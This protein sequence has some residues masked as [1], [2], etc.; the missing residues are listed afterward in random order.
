[1][2]RIKA[3]VFDVDGVLKR[4][5]TA[6]DG[7]VEI[8]E[9][10]RKEYGVFVLSNNSSYSRRSYAEHLRQIGFYF[11]EKEIYVSSRSTA[12]Y[13]KKRF[14]PTP[15]YTISTGGLTEEIKNMGFR[16]V[17]GKEGERAGIVA[18][19]FDSGVDYRKL[20][21]AFRAIKNGAFFIATNEDK[22]YPVEDGELPGAG[23]SVKGLEFATGV[24]PVVIGKPNLYMLNELLK[25]SG[26]K[27]SEVLVVGDS[28]ETDIKMANKAGVKSVLIGKAR[29]YSPTYEIK[30]IRELLG[31]LHR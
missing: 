24:K 12:L 30:S 13:I 18:V 21:I 31:V 20:S 25:E 23:L 4:G 5:R 11:S 9:R 28:E 26:L 19:G 8:V 16:V 1:M 15:V 10:I 27:K 6:I 17:D 22:F 29:K 2:G 14:S 3:L 7:A